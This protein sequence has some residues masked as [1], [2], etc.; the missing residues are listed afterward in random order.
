[1]TI[2]CQI[3]SHPNLEP[4]FYKEGYPYQVCPRCGLI[5]IY[6]QPS[7]E[8]L[9]QIYQNNYYQ[10]WGNSEDEYRTIKQ[11]TFKI[12]LDLLPGNRPFHGRLLD[13][14]AATGL[15][16]EVAENYGFKSFGVEVSKDGVEA[17]FEKFNSKRVFEG[18]FDQINFS[19]L[20]GHDLFNTI[21]MVD[22]LEHVRKPNLTLSIANSLLK[23]NGFLLIGVPD[24][25]SITKK[26][27][28]KHWEHFVV[29]H[30][31]SFSRSNITM[32]LEKNGFTIQKIA[33]MPKCLTIRYVRNVFRIHDNKLG[34]LLDPMLSLIESPLDQVRFWLPVGQMMLLARKS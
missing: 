3:C 7:D 26:L 4:L 17:I 25:S 9:S 24:T 27:F 30:L 19:E 22:L 6:P 31:F 15:L 34:R 16:M 11:H 12:I 29:E 8:D 1:M 10:A 32:L 33:R 2:P 28:G 20:L 18:Y 5:R 14:G 21:V 13:V 23:S